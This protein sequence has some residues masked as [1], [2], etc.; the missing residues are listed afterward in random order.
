MSIVAL[1]NKTFKGGASPRTS[2]IS[3]NG[4]FSING[5][6]RIRGVVG[7]TNLGPG[8]YSKTGVKSSCCADGETEVKISVKNTKG[9]LSKRYDQLYYGNPCHVVQLTP[10]NSQTYI[11]KLHTINS[12]S[13][14]QFNPACP[15]SNYPEK[16]CYPCPHNRAQVIYDKG[17]IT[18]ISQSDYLKG[19]YLKS[20]AFLS[21]K[22]YG[23]EGNWEQH[24]PPNVKNRCA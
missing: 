10:Q 17:P 8:N 23:G 19:R 14:L 16:K 21:N 20:K 1:K 13:F 24:Y 3:A 22:N 2:P 9:M 7:P 6:L 5:K 11:E 18:A 15:Q 4:I 12:C